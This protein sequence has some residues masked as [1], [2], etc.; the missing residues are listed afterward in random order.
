MKKDRILENSLHIIKKY[1][2]DDMTLGSGVISGT[3]EASG[4][5]YGKEPPVNLDKKRKN[6]DKNILNPNMFR[7]KFIKD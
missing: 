5:A 4:G 6:K 1:L 2:K 7:R 3:P